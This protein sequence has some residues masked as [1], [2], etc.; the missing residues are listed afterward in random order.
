MCVG[1]SLVR[2]NRRWQGGEGALGLHILA[3]CV[4]VCGCGGRTDR[5]ID[6]VLEHDAEREEAM[7]E[8][9]FS[10]EQVAPRLA[11]V[12]ADKGQPLRGRLDMVELVWKI[13]VREEDEAIVEAL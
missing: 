4:L 9:L 13:H 12:L 5:L 8:L 11:V 6:R 3:C 10:R 7:M 1:K 2:P